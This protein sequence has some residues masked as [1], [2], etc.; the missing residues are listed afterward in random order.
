MAKDF[1]MK[2]FKATQLVNTYINI[3]NNIYSKKSRPLQKMGQGVEAQTQMIPY[4]MTI[5]GLDMTISKIN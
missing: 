4:I 2:Y 1:L 3:D 5:R